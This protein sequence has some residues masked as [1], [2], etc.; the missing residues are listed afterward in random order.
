MGAARTVAPRQTTV[1]EYLERE[2]KEKNVRHEFLDHEVV[3]LAGASP[4]HGMIKDNIR[5]ELHPSLKAEGCRAITSDLRVTVGDRYVY[6]DVVVV[7]G[8]MDLTDETPPSLRNPDLLVEVTSPS[9]KERDYD[10][11]LQ[12]YLRIDSLKEYW[13][14]ASERVSLVQYIRRGDDWIV[15]TF[16]A[17]DDTVRCDAFDVNLALTDVYALVDFTNSPDAEDETSETA[18]S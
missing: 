6:P 15:R 11:K 12:A 3:A 8:G 9:T 14:A 7:C 4:E 18:Q 5:S 13:I 16:D 17:L 10:A 1:D 2:A